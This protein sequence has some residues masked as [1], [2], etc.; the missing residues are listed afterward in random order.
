MALRKKQLDKFG[1]WLVNIF[2]MFMIR[3]QWSQR[4]EWYLRLEPAESTGFQPTFWG[5][6]LAHWALHL[7]FWDFLSVNTWSC[8]SAI[9]ENEPHTIETNNLAKMAFLLGRNH[10]SHQAI[11]LMV[12]KSQG[13]PPFGCTSHPVNN[14]MF[15]ISSELTL[16]WTR[17]IFC[18]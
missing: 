18:P 17:C 13:Q 9:F 12:Q 8:A 10:D 7:F 5:V 11:L 4:F 14:W 6:Y 1:F 16:G 15:S 2:K 3:V